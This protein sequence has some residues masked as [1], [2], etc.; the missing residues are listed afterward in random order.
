PGS[1][2]GE[3]QGTAAE[4]DDPP[5]LAAAV[6]RRRGQVQLE[7]TAVRAACGERC[8]K[9]RGVVDDDEIAWLEQPRQLAEARVQDLSLM[10]AR[11][12]QAYVVPCRSS[13]LGGLVR[14]QRL[15]D[16]ELEGN[17]AGTST[18]CRAW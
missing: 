7:R 9:R 6:G 13:R 15:R 8:R 18:S 4:L 10:A 11:H 14:C 17:H 5:G 1:Q 16:V 12:E 2:P 3:G